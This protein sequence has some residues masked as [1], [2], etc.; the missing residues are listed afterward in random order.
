MDNAGKKYVLDFNSSPRKEQGFT[1][2]VLERFMAGAASEGAETE[3]VYLASKKIADC[4]AAR[5]A[6]S[7]PPGYAATRMTFPLCTRRCCGPMS[8]SMLLRCTSAT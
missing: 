8:S 5:G 3:T 6:G 1:A 7:R 2:K 4:L